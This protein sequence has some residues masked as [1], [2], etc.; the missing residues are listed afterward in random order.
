MNEMST[1]YG[2]VKKVDFYP[3][4]GFSIEKSDGWSLFVTAK[5]HEKAGYD[6]KVGD[7]IDVTL[8]GFN[9][10]AGIIIAG[11]VYRDKSVEDIERE[12]QEWL[13]AYQREKEERYQKYKDVWQE[14]VLTLHPT[15]QKRIRRFESEDPKFWL[16]SG[17]Y[18][19]AIMLG[20]QA[21]INRAAQYAPDNVDGQVK[22][23]EWWTSLNTEQFKY[24]YKRQMEEC[25]E[26]GEG[27]SG[28]TASAAVWFAINTLTGEYNEDS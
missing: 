13:D 9:H 10:I 18:E 19:M 26:F 16:E 27:H 25:P 28:N 17:E 15:L 23:I 20:A 14:N 8:Y 1:Q 2:Y 3:E 5:E 24:D 6:P 11:L 7:D 4:G 12:R 22:W 21:L